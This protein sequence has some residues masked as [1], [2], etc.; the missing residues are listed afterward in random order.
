MVMFVC[1]LKKGVTASICSNDQHNPTFIN[2]FPLS[3]TNSFLFWEDAGFK[4][5]VILPQVLDI[6]HL[7]P[8]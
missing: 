8:C 6:E 3:G 4:T 1:L 7:K 5:E 2:P